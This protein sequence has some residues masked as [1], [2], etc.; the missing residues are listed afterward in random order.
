MRSHDEFESPERED[1]GWVKIHWE[2]G[3]V[4]SLSQA[5]GGLNSIVMANSATLVIK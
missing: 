4:Q 2:Q 1:D 5:P 3:Q